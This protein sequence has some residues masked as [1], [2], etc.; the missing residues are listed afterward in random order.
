MM[1]DLFLLRVLGQLF[2]GWGLVQERVKTTG[3]AKG[4]ANS[5][6]IGTVFMI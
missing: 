1:N 2:C 3:S 5:C 6:C 4:V